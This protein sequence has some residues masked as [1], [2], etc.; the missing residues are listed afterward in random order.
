MKWVYVLTFH[1]FFI[2]YRFL[3]LD[4]CF[5][6]DDDVLVLCKLYDGKKNKTKNCSLLSKACLWNDN[7][8]RCLPRSKI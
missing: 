1:G 6:G 7:V 8:H 3:T 2:L 4:V 5:F